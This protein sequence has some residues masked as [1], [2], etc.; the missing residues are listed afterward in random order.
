MT[1][2]HPHLRT[3]HNRAGRLAELLCRHGVSTAPHGKA[4]RLTGGQTSPLLMDTK[5][6]CLLPE[7]AALAGQLVYEKLERLGVRQVGGLESGAVPLVSAVAVVAARHMPTL[8]AFTIRKPH[9]VADVITPEAITGHFNPALDTVLVD[10]IC[11][12]GRNLERASRAVQG[13]GGRVVA[14][15]T[16]LDRDTGARERLATM[17]IVLLPVLTMDDVHNALAGMDAAS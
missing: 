15:M 3:P 5:R 14:A 17:G 10:D 7:A 8:N 6:L 13:A 16:L 11:T 2:L 4:W 9:S 12:T 1:A